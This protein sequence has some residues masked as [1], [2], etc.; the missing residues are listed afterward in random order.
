LTPLLTVTFILDADDADPLLWM[1][2]DPAVKRGRLYDL[3]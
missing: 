3:P 2:Y 1:D